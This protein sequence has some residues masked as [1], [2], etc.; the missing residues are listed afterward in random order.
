MLSFGFLS[1]KDN[2]FCEESALKNMQQILKTLFKLLGIKGTAAAAAGITLLLSLAIASPDHSK[3]GGAENTV[4]D[5][6][7]KSSIVGN[8]NTIKLY[9]DKSIHY[10]AGDVINLTLY[11]GGNVINWSLS[12]QQVN[13]IDNSITVRV[14]MPIRNGDSIT[15]IIREQGSIIFRNEPVNEIGTQQPPSTMREG[16]GLGFPPM[17]RE[18]DGNQSWTQTLDPDLTVQT[19]KTSIYRDIQDPID[20]EEH[21]GIRSFLKPIFG[22][23]I[24]DREEKD[25]PPTA[26]PW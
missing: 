13:T 15:N 8:N 24:P 17:R 7:V 3:R 12:V 23:L 11:R 10:K 2:I 20:P 14:D 26:C 19:S 22:A 21:H 6:H 1:P 16:F 18:H 5:S 4:I 25:T 9:I